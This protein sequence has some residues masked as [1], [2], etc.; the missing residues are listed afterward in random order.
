VNPFQSS[1]SSL[2]RLRFQ[3]SSISSMADV[4]PFQ[5]AVPEQQI[6]DLKRRLALAKFPHDELDGSGW[7]Y[8]SPLADV[9]RLAAYWRDLFDW[10]KTEARLNQLPHFTTN[11]QCDGF[12]SL[13][14]HLL[15]KQSNVEAAIPLLFVHGCE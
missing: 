14:I 1:A 13:K 4:T 7:D 10:R 11:I 6:V 9:K 2:L 5:I 8:G 15:H 3:R 12:E